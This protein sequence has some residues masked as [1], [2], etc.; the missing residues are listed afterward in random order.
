MKSSIAALILAASLF[1]SVVRSD[2]QAPAPTPKPPGPS[3]CHRELIRCLNLCKEK[4]ID[5]SIRCWDRLDGCRP[6]RP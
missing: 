3:A 6:G 2:G 1:P 5:C 4:D